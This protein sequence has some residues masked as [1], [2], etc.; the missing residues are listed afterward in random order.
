MYKYMSMFL[1]TYFSKII[2]EKMAS[3]TVIKNCITCYKISILKNNRGKIIIVFC[4]SI[5]IV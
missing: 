1:K 4:L 2:Y 3:L 5:N